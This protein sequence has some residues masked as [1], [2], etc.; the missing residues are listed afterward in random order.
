MERDV[1]P[2]SLF[3]RI[4]FFG[5]RNIC[6]S[7]NVA[8]THTHTHSARKEREEKEGKRHKTDKRPLSTIRLYRCIGGI[9][10]ALYETVQQSSIA[11]CPTRYDVWA[12][13]VSG[14]GVSLKT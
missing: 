1:V 6:L 9:W 7:H 5:V 10:Y 8:K 13:Y 2:A 12:L 14:Y 4:F 11:F 3:I